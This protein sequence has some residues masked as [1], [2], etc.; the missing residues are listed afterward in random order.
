MKEQE[1]FEKWYARD[2][3]RYKYKLKNKDEKGNYK[4]PYLRGLYK[5]WLAS[6]KIE[7]GVEC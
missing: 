4:S 7:R 5:S 1:R 2:Q 3:Y 6:S